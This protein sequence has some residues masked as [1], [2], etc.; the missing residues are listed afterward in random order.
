MTIAYIGSNLVALLLLFLSWKKKNLARTLFAILFVWASWINWKTA[1]NN[2]GDYL[3]YTQYAI[4]FYKGIIQDWFSK[5]ITAYVSIIAV[6]QLLIGLGFL[7][8]GVIVK[9][10]CIGAIIFLLAIAPLGFGS[11]FPFSLIASAALI[12]L[13]RHYFEKNIFRNKWFA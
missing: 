2:P 3:N 6:A 1:H 8:K 12:I 7:S 11:A 13:Y 5:H 10:S 9:I 4:G